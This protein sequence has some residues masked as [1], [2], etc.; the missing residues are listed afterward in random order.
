MSFVGW[1]TKIVRYKKSPS[2]GVGHGCHS[3]ASR[4]SLKANW[5][6][7]IVVNIGKKKKNI[8]AKNTN[9]GIL[10]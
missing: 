7:L 3:V 5:S 9:T 6:N 2:S 10:F 4:L 1:Q 8:I